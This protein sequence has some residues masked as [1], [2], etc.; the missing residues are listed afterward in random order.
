M[1]DSR[2]MAAPSIAINTVNQPHICTP[3]GQ[4]FF[5]LL[6]LG[7]LQYTSDLSRGYEKLD[8][9]IHEWELWC[10]EEQLHALGLLGEPPQAGEGSA[11]ASALMAI[12]QGDVSTLFQASTAGDE[13]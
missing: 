4:L 12:D 1:C 2:V 13:P 11:T 3:I 9:N 5:R 7:I 6:L 8:E 10:D